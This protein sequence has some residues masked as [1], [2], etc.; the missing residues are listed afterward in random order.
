MPSLP[1]SAMGL[2][3]QLAPVLKTFLSPPGLK[4]PFT[5]SSADPGRERYRR[6]GM[7]AAT[8]YIARGYEVRRIFRAASR[9]LRRPEPHCTALRNLDKRSS[10]Y[11]GIMSIGVD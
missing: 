9:W 10:R 5:Q 6:A 3:R 11:R 4:T 7:T 1:F 2:P 8:S